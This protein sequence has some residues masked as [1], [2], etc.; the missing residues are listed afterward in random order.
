MNNKTI[1]NKKH[2]TDMSMP[3]HPIECFECKLFIAFMKCFGLT[4][5]DIK[6]R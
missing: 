2:S 3:T 4:E 6:K 5:D 1:A